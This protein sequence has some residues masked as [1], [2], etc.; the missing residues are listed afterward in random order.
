MKK[1]DVAIISAFF[2]TPRNNSLDQLTQ[3]Q[4]IVNENIKINLKMKTGGKF[5]VGEIFLYW[6]FISIA[7]P[8][9]AT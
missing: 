6:N 3:I 5:L 8:L 2:S 9:Q 1:L 7:T 4:Q